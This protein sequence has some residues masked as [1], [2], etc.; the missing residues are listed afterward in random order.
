MYIHTKMSKPLQKKM[1]FIQKWSSSRA[2]YNYEQLWLMIDW[3]NETPSRSCN[4]MFYS[5][6]CLLYIM[7]VHVCFDCVLACYGC[8]SLFLFLSFSISFFLSLSLFLFLS[9]SLCLSLSLSF[10]LSFSLSLSLSLSLF[11]SLSL[12]FFSLSSFAMISSKDTLYKNSGWPGV[13][14]GARQ[15]LMDKVQ[16]LSGVS[17]VV[18]DDVWCWCLLLLAKPLQ[19]QSY[20]TFFSVLQR[21][22][23]CKLCFWAHG[24]L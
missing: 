6:F 4:I 13:K 5:S 24:I 11:F 14:H 18:K 20:V 16:G 22:T 19:L 3:S 8:L 2:K 10:S 1:C 23:V 12:C 9:F 17:A 15:R 7:H 21:C